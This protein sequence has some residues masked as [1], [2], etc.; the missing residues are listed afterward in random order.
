M[1]NSYMSVLVNGNPTTNFKVTRGLRQGDPLFPFLFILAAEGFAG[2]V[3]QPVSLREF[4]GFHLNIY[5]HFD[6]LQFSVDT[7][8]IKEGI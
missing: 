5:A 6:L 2:L 1:F 4:D 3:H 7:I 8:L